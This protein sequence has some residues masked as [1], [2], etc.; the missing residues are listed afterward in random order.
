MG[1]SDIYAAQET[2]GV[3]IQGPAQRHDDYN[4]YIHAGRPQGEGTS[5]KERQD[6]NDVHTSLLPLW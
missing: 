6:N 1:T 3:Y 4:H 2:S 5:K